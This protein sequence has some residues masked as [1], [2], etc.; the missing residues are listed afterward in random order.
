MVFK[1]ENLGKKNSDIWSNRNISFECR[2]G[3]VVGLVGNN[4]KQNQLPK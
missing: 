3:E 2:G 1:V 4:E